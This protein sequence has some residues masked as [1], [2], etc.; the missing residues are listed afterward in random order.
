MPN[1][2]EDE[3]NPDTTTWWLDIPDEDATGALARHVAEIIGAGDL[4]TLGG[5]LGAGKTSFARALV[6]HLCKDEEL[7]VPS[8]TFTLMQVYVGPGF[9]IVHADLYRIRSTDE[10]VELGWDEAAEGALVLVEWPERAGTELS[11]DRLDI[12]F[13]ADAAQGES[14]RRVRLTGHGAMAPKLARAKGIDR[15]LVRSGWGEAARSFMLGD[16]STRAYERLV[17]PDGSRAVLMI[18]PP[19]PD[20]PPVRY[21]KPYSAIARLAEDIRPFVAMAQAIRTHDLSAPEIYAA[22]LDT[23]LAIIEDLGSQTVVDDNGPIPERYAE[24]V[25]VLAKLH[26]EPLPDSVPLGEQNYRIPPYDMDALLIE[27]E[28]LTEWYAPHISAN[29]SSGACAIFVNLWRNALREIVDGRK[30]WVLRDYHSPNLIWLP[31]REGLKRIGIIDFQDA[32]LGSPAYDVA[33]ILQDARVDVSDELEIRLLSHYARLRRS[34]NAEFDMGAF[35]RDYALMSAQ[36][37]TK[38]LGIFARLNRRDRKPQYLAHIP[39]VRR[40]L[41][42]SLAHPALAELKTWYETHMPAVFENGA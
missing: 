25:A 18:S 23:G 41:A 11:P 24:A 38:I 19:R 12:A 34:R 20:G 5:D 42:K 28:L 22:D 1:A 14:W 26:D 32:V 35:A 4:V 33:S 29:L 36:R 9:P 15:L 13:F 27:A 37:A 6:R 17:K 31:E 10:L 39:R 7:E 2:R 21:G 3:Q 16:A 40:Y 8:P 30:T